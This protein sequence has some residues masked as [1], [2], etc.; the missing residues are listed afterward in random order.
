MFGPTFSHFFP[1]SFSRQ[2]VGP[3]PHGPEA[4]VSGAS[5]DNSAAYSPFRDSKCRQKRNSRSVIGF[6]LAISRGLKEDGLAPLN[7]RSP[8]KQRLVFFPLFFLLLFHP[9]SRNNVD[10]NAEYSVFI[11]TFIYI[12]SLRFFISPL[13]T[14]HR[15]KTDVDPVFTINKNNDFLSRLLRSLVKMSTKFRKTVV[16]RTHKLIGQSV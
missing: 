3:S 5:A 13:A 9:P 6:E 2:S 11:L 10:D 15:Q 14:E 8:E 16:F 1:L 7:H 12:F 4:I